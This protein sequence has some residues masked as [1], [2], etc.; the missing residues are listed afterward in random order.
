MKRIG[1]LSLAL[2]TFGIISTSCEGG[3][4]ECVEQFKKEGLTESEAVEKCDEE[5][6]ETV[7]AVR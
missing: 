6:M 3:K 2:V 1:F 7:E 4:D 5:L